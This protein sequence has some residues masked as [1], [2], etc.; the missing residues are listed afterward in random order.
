MTEFSS[1]TRCHS[2]HNDNEFPFKNTTHFFD[3]YSESVW[4]NFTYWHL[5]IMWKMPPLSF[6][7]LAG[8]GFS[9][10]LF[11]QVI[12]EMPDLVYM[13]AHMLSNSEYNCF[14]VL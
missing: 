14:F 9:Y 13:R 6:S 5:N 2:K 1:A 12:S 10:S 8:M 3:Q 7:M 11:I 4:G